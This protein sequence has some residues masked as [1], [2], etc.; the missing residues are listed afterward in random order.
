MALRIEF[1]LH[2]GRDHPQP[3]QPEPPAVYDTAPAYIERDPS[4]D[5]EADP[6]VRQRIGFTAKEETP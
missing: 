2:I 5:T 3:E 4:L 1:H 6:E